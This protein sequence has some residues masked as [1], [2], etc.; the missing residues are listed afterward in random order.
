MKLS[1]PA[2]DCP[3]EACGP[4]GGVGAPVLSR[5]GPLS[6]SLCTYSVRMMKN[7]LVEFVI[8]FST[9][10][11]APGA[12]LKETSTVLRAIRFGV[13]APAGLADAATLC[14]GA[15]VGVGDDPRSSANARRRSDVMLSTLAS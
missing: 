12:A 10:R 15:G 7:W 6:F 5:G 1:A 9:F 13:A 14:P 8:S 3:G 2:G 4:G 11:A